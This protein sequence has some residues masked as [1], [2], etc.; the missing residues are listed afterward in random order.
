M[1]A[2]VAVVI[3]VVALGAWRL[4][5]RRHPNWATSDDARFYISTGTWTALIA[6]YWFLQSQQE[7]HWVWDAWPVLVVA[8]A[9]L[10]LRGLN[11]LDAAH[12]HEFVPTPP[13]R[14]RSDAARSNFLRLGARR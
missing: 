6:L 5:V 12:D 9:L 14:S 7:P 2:T 13:K 10:L 4:R 3:A 11:A 1:S 8:A